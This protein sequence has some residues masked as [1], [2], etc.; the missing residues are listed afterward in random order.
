MAD[1]TIEVPVIEDVTDQYDFSGMDDGGYGYDQPVVQEVAA[2][3]AVTAEEEVTDPPAKETTDPSTPDSKGGSTTFDYAPFTE[4]LGREVNSPEE[5]TQAINDLKN[6]RETLLDPQTLSE[7]VRQ[8]MELEKSGKGTKDFFKELGRDYEAMSDL[9]LLLQAELSKKENASL[10]REYLTERFNRQWEEKSE[11]IA[12]LDS[13]ELQEQYQEKHDLSDAQME[14]VVKDAKF[15][16]MELKNE[17]GIARSGFQESQQQMLSA[18]NQE[19]SQE[20]TEQQAAAEAARKE[21]QSV[22]VKEA[23]KYQKVSLKLSDR[24]RIEDFNIGLEG[25][26]PEETAKNKEA[27]TEFLK[28]PALSMQS[29]LYSNFLDEGGKVD[30]E[31]LSKFYYIATNFNRIPEMITSHL[32]HQADLSV[33]L[34]EKENPPIRGNEGSRVE[35]TDREAKLEAARLAVRSWQ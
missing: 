26:T 32:S 27:F 35:K 34:E 15:Y 19:K 10:D 2:E 5:L 6:S 16:Q 22:A 30:F 29:F 9:D 18:F 12:L 13:E 24:E 7:P 3:E 8:L 25:K 14:R 28:E 21:H 1:E 23:E 17:A 20:L 11:K 4:T 31:G 33:M